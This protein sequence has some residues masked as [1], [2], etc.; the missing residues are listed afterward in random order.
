MK[1]RTAS[2]NTGQHYRALA[3]F[4]GRTAER[5]PISRRE[6]DVM[7]KIFYLPLEA[8]SSRYTLQLRDWT[9]RRFAAR[10]VP[11]QTIEGRSLRSDQAIKTGRVLD[12]HGRSHWAL[13][14]TAELVRLLHDGAISGDD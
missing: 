11:F 9:E 2:P 1:P 12:A 7:T 14:Q 8:Y 5:Y 6:N 13:T 10:G 3:A 4:P